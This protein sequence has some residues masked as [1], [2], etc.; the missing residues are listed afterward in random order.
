MA[1][2][3]NK[4]WAWAA[5]AGATV[6]VGMAAGNGSGD[7]PPKVGTVISLNIDG[8]GERQFKVIKSEKQPDGTYLSD[9]K[10]TKSGETITLL[11]KA[12]TLPAGPKTADPP[13]APD[14]P[15][16]K[17]RTNDPLSPPMTATLDPDKTKAP[18]KRPILGRIFGDKDK[19]T[20]PASTSNAMP[21][22]DA[23]TDPAQKPGLLG[24]IFGSKKSSGSNMP[25]ATAASPSAPALK[26]SS[27]TPPAVLPVPPGGLTT[28]TAP[29]STNEPPRVMPAKPITPP[30]SAA[31][32]TPT[33]A[34][35]FPTAPTT[36]SS[37]PPVS[38]PAPLPP[39]PSVPVPAV[40]P[41]LP[42]PTIPV[43]QGGAGL[44]PI[45][46]P[47]GGTSAAQPIQVV[48][49]AGYV[50]PQ[51]AFDREVQPFVI[52][53]QSM[54][55]PSARLT[56]AKALADGR[57]G[58]TDGVKGVLFQAA[59]M[60]PCGEVRAA[61]VTHLCTLGYY[62]PQFLGHI[63]TACNDTDEQVRAAAKAACEK[64][65]RK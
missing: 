45:P 63:Q 62:T 28:P 40:P 12:E 6:T 48:L 54:A 46:V 37:V 60:D 65:I 57:H 15:K 55:A 13:K 53:L 26:P 29:I 7:G 38:I 1:R 56:A 11:D 8:K 41:P 25:A 32:V 18:E 23:Q 42:V 17:P 61:C 9:L 21:K 14:V 22:T 49:P 30:T 3:F 10:D 34:P 5:L 47:P 19:P 36:G 35:T 39:A 20:P 16:A 43:P 52:A 64:M 58:S 50:P 51:V 2:W 31:P 33:P 24:R 4:R 59:Q 44:P 27:S